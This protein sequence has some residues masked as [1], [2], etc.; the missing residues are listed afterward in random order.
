MSPGLTVREHP[1]GPAVVTSQPL[2]IKGERTLT[3]SPTR[4]HTSNKKDAVTKGEGNRGWVKKTSSCPQQALAVATA[5]RPCRGYTL[6]TGTKKDADT[7]KYQT[8]LVIG[9]RA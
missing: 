9:T 8:E 2:V 3:K 7:S 5:F 1:V 6:V 4:L